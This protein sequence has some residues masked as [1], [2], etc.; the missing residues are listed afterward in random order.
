MLADL[1]TLVT[2]GDADVRLVTLVDLN[3]I[4]GEPTEVVVQLPE[5]YELA[6]VTGTS[7]ERS[8]ERGRQVALFVAAPSQRRHQFLLTLTQSTAGGSFKL[9]RRSRD[10]R[11]PARNRRSRYRRP[12]DARDC[13]E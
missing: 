11:R 12:R 10:R 9:E 2:I 3:V 4:Q 13:V 1:K 7:L 5:G 6:G 8:E